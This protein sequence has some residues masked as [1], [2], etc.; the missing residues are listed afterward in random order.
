MCH[1]GRECEIKN[2]KDKTKE[3]TRKK[4]IIGAT[5]SQA[6]RGQVITCEGEGREGQSC[7]ALFR[8]PKPNQNQT[9]VKTTRSTHAHTSRMVHSEA[10]KCAGVCEQLWMEM[11]HWTKEQYGDAITRTRTHGQL[12]IN[13]IMMMAKGRFHGV[14]NNMYQ[15]MIAQLHSAGGLRG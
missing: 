2:L 12:N 11:V 3:K 4:Q 1:G 14:D 6:N 7:A 5:P 10:G 15:H 13:L 8:H 9:S